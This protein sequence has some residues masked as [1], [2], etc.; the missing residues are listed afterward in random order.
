MMITSGMARRPI[1]WTGG[2]NSAAGAE[3]HG[4]ICNHLKDAF[5]QGTQR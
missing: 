3:G 2:R 4:K 1:R 5:R